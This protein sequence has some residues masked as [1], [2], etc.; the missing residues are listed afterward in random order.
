MPPPNR[1]TAAQHHIPDEEA[2]NTDEAE[3]SLPRTEAAD[4]GAQTP[5][6]SWRHPVNGA[7]KAL[8][9]FTA[10]RRI[11][12][13]YNSVCARCDRPIASGEVIG[14]LPREVARYGDPGWVCLSCQTTSQASFDITMQHVI[15]RVYLRW[16]AG[17]PVGLNKGE[18][19]TLCD[20]AFHADAEL[21]PATR[22]NADDR[23]FDPVRPSAP[24]QGWDQFDASIE[25]IVGH[26]VDAVNYQFACS[27][28]TSNVFVLLSHLIEHTCTCGQHIPPDLLCVYE[29][30][31]IVN[32]WDNLDWHHPTR[33][34]GQAAFAR[35]FPTTTLPALPS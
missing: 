7:S 17:K 9:A 2:M 31:E 13:R 4:G 33:R 15:A 1:V 30:M 20:A 5:K 26:L 6:K 19:E 14:R 23:D 21:E 10:G 32:A 29:L 22:C 3:P 27:L 18:V 8:R 16:A 24:W 11:A 35:R 25:E 12:A 28:S 34:G